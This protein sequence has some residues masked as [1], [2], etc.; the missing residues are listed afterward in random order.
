MS[1]YHALAAHR[2]LQSEESLTHRLGIKHYTETVKRVA[3]SVVGGLLGVAA[4]TAHPILGALVGSALVKGAVDVAVGEASVSQAAQ[5]VGKSVIAAAGS[6]ASPAMPVVGYGAGV[7]L[8]NAIFGVD[9]APTID[10]V[11]A[12]KA[13]IRKGMRGTSIARLQYLLGM[14]GDDIDGIYGPRTL[15]RVEAFQKSV[16]L[17]FEDGDVGANTIKELESALERPAGNRIP[18]IEVTPVAPKRAPKGALAATST[19]DRAIT[20]ESSFFEKMRQP[21]AEG[22]S[23]T[24]GHVGLVGAGLALGVAGW[25]LTRGGP[26]VPSTDFIAGPY[27]A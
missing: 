19:A 18:Q 8:G 14:T 25:L 2:L 12:G 6:L 5:G 3:P 21:I 27:G 13:V 9:A 20:P 24:V 11:R 4:S 26:S 10:D 17:R 16:N 22:S 23:V 7:L 1:G 15:A